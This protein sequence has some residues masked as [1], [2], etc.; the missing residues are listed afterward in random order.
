MGARARSGENIP[1]G[2]FDLDFA[3]HY[4]MLPN[5]IDLDSL[6]G[7]D[8]TVNLGLPSGRAVEIFGPP[9][10]GKSSMAHRVVGSAQKLGHTC[11]WIDT[12]HSYAENLAELNG[13]DIDSL[14]YSELFD[15]D[16]PDKN[17]HAEDVLDN[18]CKAAESGVKVIVLDSVANLIPKERMEKS[19]QQILIARLARCL[20]DNF[21]KVVH[22]VAKYDAIL[23]CINHIRKKPGV[24]FGPDED[25]P[26][27]FMLKHDLSL[28]LRMTLRGAK[29]SMIFIENEEGKQMLIGRQSGVVLEKN[30]M[31][32]PLLDPETGK[33]ITLDI[34][35]YYE[36]YFPN[37]EEIVF[38]AARQLKIVKV[39][40]GVYSWDALKIDGKNAFVQEVITKGMLN[41]LGKE[42]QTKAKEDNVI[43]PPE[44]SKHNFKE[45]P[46]AKDVET[47]ET[48]QNERRSA[49]K[50]KKTTSG[51]GGPDSVE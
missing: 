31:G 37:I 25:S 2:H 48:T 32:K 10:C 15:Q 51:T 11:L 17:F 24:M 36:P 47:D 43:L 29:D 38:S 40:Q 8:P 16:D 20:A 5:N 14:L 6:E 30:R 33:K 46:K 22:Y 23:I 50:R 13:V 42:V 35:I 1:T 21:S 44:M 12:E 26:G 3:I 9:S 49:K 27:G 41:R 39:R 7:Y 34:P 28:R 4:G 18:I 19:A 45:D